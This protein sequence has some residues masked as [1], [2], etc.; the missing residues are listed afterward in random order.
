MDR[1]TLL[2]ELDAL[3]FAAQRDLL[4]EIG[5]HAMRRVPIRQCCT[6]SLERMLGD[7]VTIF[8]KH[9]LHYWVDFGVLLGIVRTGELIAYDHDLDIGIFDTAIDQYNAIR[10][11]LDDLGYRTQPI[12]RQKLQSEDDF[13]PRIYPPG[14]P[15]HCAGHIC[16]DLFVWHN[17]AKR[18]PRKSV[19]LNFSEFLYCDSAYYEER[20]WLEWKGHQLPVPKNREMYLELRYGP[21][22]RKADPLFYHHHKTNGSG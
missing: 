12:C 22:W 5:L 1:S 15:T 16:C 19:M 21:K 6:A 11:E 4:A 17:L 18:H 9:Q 13:V 10:Q 7:V 14:E 8:N 20:E 3:D 2:A